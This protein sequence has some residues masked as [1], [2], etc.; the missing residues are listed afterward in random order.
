MNLSKRTEG[1]H[2]CVC[3]KVEAGP[4]LAAQTRATLIE[5]HGRIAHLEATQ[6][7]H[8]AAIRRV[9]EVD[10]DAI[11][12]LRAIGSSARPSLPSDGAA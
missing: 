6:G 5:F 12:E 1:G 4:D 9:A 2:P 11:A 10:S 8:D 7:R 3:K